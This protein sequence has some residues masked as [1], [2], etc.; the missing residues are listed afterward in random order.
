MRSDASHERTRFVYAGSAVALVAL[1]SALWWTAPRL[2]D[3]GPTDDRLRQGPAMNGDPGLVGMW[4]R[5][6][7]EQCA[8]R[9]ASSLHIEANGL[10]TGKP[11]EA[12]GFTWWDAGTWRVNS[13]GQLAMSVAN[14][15]VITYRYTLSGD[16]LRI[17]D[18]EGCTVAYRRSG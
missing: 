17:T 6:G 13:P 8:A 2:A 10:Y 3:D 18:A 11:A 7:S 16:A 4:Q 5:S 14:D 1:L 9:Y 15:E 12:G